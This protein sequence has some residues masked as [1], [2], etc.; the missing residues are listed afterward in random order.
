MAT[1]VEGSAVVFAIAELGDTSTTEMDKILWGGH[2]VYI[3]CKQCGAHLSEE[4]RLADGSEC[5][6]E[7][8]KAYVPRGT[9]I[10]NDDL[11]FHQNVGGYI[12]NVEDVLH[13]E[14][15]KD[16]SRLSGCCGFDGMDGPN[17]LCDQCGAEVATKK[18]DCWM[19]H[20]VLFEPNATNVL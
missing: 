9:T 10:Q 6:T 20:C 19:P 2:A 15:T 7:D 17:L 14:L 8:G 18:T 4:L 1:A 5:N 16:A 13:T 11:F 12:A 3:V